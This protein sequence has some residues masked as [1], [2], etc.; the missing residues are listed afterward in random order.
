MWWWWWW[1]WSLPV[2]TTYELRSH[3]LL[4]VGPWMTDKADSCGE[5]TTAVITDKATCICGLVCG[6]GLTCRTCASLLQWQYELPQHECTYLLTYLLN[7]NLCPVVPLNNNQSVAVGQEKPSCSP[8]NVNLSFFNVGLLLGATCNRN[9]VDWQ[10]PHVA[11]S[12]A[13][14]RKPRQSLHLQQCLHF[15][16]LYTVR[17]LADLQ[18]ALTRG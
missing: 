2:G 4:P 11:Y 12:A 6:E 10:T 14:F 3:S 16:V 5:L 9:H 17:L 15:N 18:P 8:F 1:W 13:G 7:Y